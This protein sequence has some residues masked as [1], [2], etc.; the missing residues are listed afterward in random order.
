MKR[1]I[2]PEFSSNPLNMIKAA[3]FIIAGN[4]ISNSTDFELEARNGRKESRKWNCKKN[5][6][7]DWTDKSYCT[8]NDINNISY[9][10][11]LTCTS[12]ITNQQ[13][14]ISK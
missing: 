9:F 13:K 4:K 6:I 14:K 12:A 1:E 8:G 10:V 2:T 5:I 7:I 3:K 11:C